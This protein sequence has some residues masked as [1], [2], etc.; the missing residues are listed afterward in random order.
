MNTMGPTMQQANDNDYAYFK[1]VNAKENT[2]TESTIT[3]LTIRRYGRQTVAAIIR[4]RRANVT[5]K[6]YND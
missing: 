3:K 1:H 5:D 4:K 2:T 6:Q